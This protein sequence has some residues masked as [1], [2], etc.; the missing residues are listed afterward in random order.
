[1]KSFADLVIVELAGSLAG[2]YCGKLF[3]DHG[4]EV[5]LLGDSP[6]PPDQAIY[7]NAGK[8]VASPPPGLVSSDLVARADVVIQSAATRA[9]EP[10]EMGR[11]EI[12]DLQI[13]PFGST[14]PY[15]DRRGSDLTDYAL[16]GHLYL[17]GDPKREPL[18][19]PPNQPQYASGLFGFIG[20][21][22]ALL[23]REQTGHGQVVEVSHVEAM[24]ALHQFTMLRHNLGGDI[25]RRMGNRFTGQGQPNSIYPSADG[26]VCV[27]APTSDQVERLLEITEL[28]YLLERDDIDSPMDFQVKPE[29]L[30]NV[31]GPWLAQRNTAEIVELLQAVRVPSTPTTDMAGLLADEQL[32]SRGYWRGAGDGSGRR[33]PGPPFRMSNH[34]WRGEAGQGQPSTSQPANAGPMGWQPSS[35][36]VETL[37]QTGPLAGLKVLDLTRVWAGPL[38]TRVLSELGADVVWIEAP[39]SRGPQRMPE[40]VIETVKY[41]PNNDQGTCQWNRNGHAIKFAAGKRSLVLDLSTEAGVATFERLVPQADV[42]IENYSSRVMPQ[43]GLDENRLHQLNADLIY[44]TMPG[45][46]RD[47]PA[48]HWLAYGSSID[49]HAGLSSLIGYRDQSPWKGGVAWPDPIAG[50]HA[51]G[52]LLMALWDRESA[53]AVGKPGGQ[54]IESAQFEAT[55]AVVGDQVLAAQRRDQ[56]EPQETPREDQSDP[57]RSAGPGNR[58]EAYAP[59]GVYRCRGEDRWLAL[60]VFDDDGWRRLCEIASFGEEM[61]KLSARHRHQQHDEIDR[62]LSAWSSAHEQIELAERLQMAGLAAAP[63]LDAAGLVVDP[64]LIARD[65]FATFEQPEVGLFSTPRIPLHLSATPSHVRRRA[66]ML[67]EH[68]AEVLADWGGLTDVEIAHLATDGITATEPPE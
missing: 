66:P 21:L 64:H 68:N 67:G 38:A 39:W 31:L 2:A 7:T 11:D 30:D 55:V 25:L 60:T 29:V 56:V 49:S 37:A 1:M 44:V 52:A 32:A 50:L 43:L 40:S 54:T 18:R 41:F 48:E 36:T 34:H 6:L 62:Q 16:S 51:A 33:V 17:Y 10:V 58:H 35:R 24:A 5:V 14:G 63:V 57:G 42:V 46:G 26:W 19:G 23:A 15:A 13:S 45:Y 59:Q 4:A 8:T 65:F 61:A 27:S 28:G 47:G 3:A 20:S 22:A 12:V 53:R 9:V